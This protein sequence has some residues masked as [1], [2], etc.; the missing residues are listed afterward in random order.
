[1]KR[2]S[3][4]LALAFLFGA[5]HAQTL[6]EYIKLRK[7]YGI[8]QAVGVQALETLVGT[9]VLEIQGNV[10]G[11]LRVDSHDTLLLE[12]TDGDFIFVSCQSAPGWLSGNEI[13]VR[14]IVKAE[15]SSE[16]GELKATLI[17]AATESQVAPLEVPAKVRS[18][19]KGSRSISFVSPTVGKNWN[20]PVSEAAPIYASYIMR[21][22]GRLSER[23][24]LKIAEGVIGFS[25]KYGVDAR[26]IMAM[27]MCESGFN[28]N[29]V[30]RTGAMGLGQLMPGTARGL[31]V[32]NAFDSNEN[33]YGTV[34]LIRGHLDK[35]KRQT[36]DE[37]EG[38]I[39]ALAAY[40]AGGGAVAK[41]GGVPPFKETQSY[42]RKVS[43]LYFSLCGR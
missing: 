37:Y 29:A 5:S 38:L 42:V 20:L 23:E 1:M 4:T 7:Q 21:R 40:N 25:V 31:G 6:A 16:Q 33:L 28:P 41:H 17:G 32:G 34:K 13:P 9:K 3:T 35:Y 36:G 43:S 30:S 2:L 22:N 19:S 24:A 18:S 12:K 10:K 26:L 8:T 27:V 39:L 14:M 11:S 15:R